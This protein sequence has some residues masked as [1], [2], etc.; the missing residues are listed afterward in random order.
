MVLTIDSEIFTLPIVTLTESC[1]R[2]DNE[3]LL[4]GAG[5]GIGERDR[6]TETERER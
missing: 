6:E 2:S 1:R 3:R 5:I 4:T